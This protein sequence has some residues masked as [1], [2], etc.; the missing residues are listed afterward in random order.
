MKLFHSS[1]KF[2][3]SN[4]SGLPRD[5]HIVGRNEAWILNLG[6]YGWR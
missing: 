3:M 5:C 2:D 4:R 6:S 1:S